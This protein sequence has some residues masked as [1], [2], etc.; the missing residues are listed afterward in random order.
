MT[1]CFQERE[2]ARNSGGRSNS[3]EV[4]IPSCTSDGNFA[5]VQC[6]K[7]SGYCWCVSKE[8]KPFP[9]TSSKNKKPN[10]RGK[11]SVIKVSG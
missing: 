5:E 11:C 9:G 7:A 2:E 10:C 6:H 8:G 3:K 4:F 1:K